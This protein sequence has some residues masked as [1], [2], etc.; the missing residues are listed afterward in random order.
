MKQ[1]FVLKNV[2]ASGYQKIGAGKIIRAGKKGLGRSV[3]NAGRNLCSTTHS[4]KGLGA[5][6]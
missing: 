1:G 2:M 5:I 6:L 3:N 4:A